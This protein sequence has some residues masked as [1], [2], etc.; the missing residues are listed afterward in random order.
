MGTLADIEMM[1][2]IKAAAAKAFGNVPG[3]VGFGY[4]GKVLNVICVGRRV[5]RWSPG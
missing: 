5:F 3:V 2:A 4:L 1:K